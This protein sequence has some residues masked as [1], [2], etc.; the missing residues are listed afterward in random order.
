MNAVTFVHTRTCMYNVCFYVCIRLKH[1]LLCVLQASVAVY[2]IYV[3]S[4]LGFYAVQVGS[5]LQAFRDSVSVPSSRV[6][7]VIDPCVTLED[8][9]DTLSRNV[10]TDY[11]CTALNPRRTGQISCSSTFMDY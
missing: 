1:I 5:S 10:G 8:G 9:T 11:R 7:R 4:F 3:C 2:M 6:K